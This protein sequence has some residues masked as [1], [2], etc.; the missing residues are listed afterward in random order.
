MAGDWEVWDVWLD[1]VLYCGTRV[2]SPLPSP[3]SPLPSPLSP[4]IPRGFSN[5]VLRG[6]R[7]RERGKSSRFLGPLTLAA[8]PRWISQTSGNVLARGRATVLI[9]FNL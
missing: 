9:W 1:M 8:L 5:D 7:V 4:R 3:L 6:E 2:L